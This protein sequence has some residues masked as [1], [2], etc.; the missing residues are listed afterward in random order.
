MRPW[1]LGTSGLVRA[2][3]NTWLASCA[4]LV[5]IFRP[6][7]TQPAPARAAAVLA[8]ATSEPVSGSV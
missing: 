2:S 3:T 7:I 1:C 4:V 5:N 8:D 6:L